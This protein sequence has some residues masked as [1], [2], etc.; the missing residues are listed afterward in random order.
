MIDASV[1]GEGHNVIE[2]ILQRHRRGIKV[3]VTVDEAVED[4]FKY[5]GGE[6]TSHLS[7]G[8]MWHPFKDGESLDFWNY[9]QPHYDEDTQY[10][11]MHT[12]ADLLVND[13]VPNISFL[14]MKGA[15]LSK[16]FVVDTVIQR[17][18]LASIA[19]K[20][21]RGAEQFYAQ[22]IQ[23]VRLGIFVS[24]RELGRKV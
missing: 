11:L 12:G 3:S 5:W 4:F 17:D 9:E 16:S 13:R 19:R 18:R 20:L 1:A 7:H 10:S 24:V 8:R 6:A 21:N 23:D 15:T 14:R 22:Y 2:I